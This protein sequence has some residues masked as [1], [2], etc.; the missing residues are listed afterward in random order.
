MTIIMIIIIAM[1][2]MITMIIMIM[3]IA[4]P[5]VQCAGPGAALQQLRPPPALPAAT[6]AALPRGA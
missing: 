6:A 3:I 2:I 4:Q 1:I 5:A